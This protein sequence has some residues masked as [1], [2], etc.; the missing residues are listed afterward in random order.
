[1]IGVSG[2]NKVDSVNFWLWKTH[3][4]IPVSGRCSKWFSMC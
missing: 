1:M 3:L 4:F 2:E